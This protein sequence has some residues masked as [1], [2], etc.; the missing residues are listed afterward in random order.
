MNCSAV[1]SCLA[2]MLCL[3]NGRVLA[4]EVL[5]APARTL[6]LEADLI[7]VGEVQEDSYGDALVRVEEVLKGAAPRSIA[8]DPYGAC[9][10]RALN[11]GDRGILFLAGVG[12]E[13]RLVWGSS[14]WPVKGIDGVRTSLRMA[15]A[16]ERFVG[17]ARYHEDLDLIY[18]LGETF[19]KH[20]VTSKEAPV[21][22]AGLARVLYD[23]GN[24]GQP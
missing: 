10:T 8:V 4:C 20:P 17:S 12:P 1:A 5:Q 18:I 13:Y 21:L 6:I 14:P 7:I 16:P 22:A 24:G 2:A 15:A 23:F 9:Q 11:T 19:S 3:P